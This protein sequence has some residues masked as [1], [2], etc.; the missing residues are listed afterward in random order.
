MGVKVFQVPRRSSNNP[1]GLR[2]H[3]DDARERMTGAMHGVASGFV[4][5]CNPIQVQRPPVILPVQIC[6]EHSNQE[7]CHHDTVSE[8]TLICTWV[9]DEVRVADKRGHFV[10]KI[11]EFY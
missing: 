11:H 9:V 6:A 7:R 5:S 3:S 10:L 2:G 8:R 1:S 4:S